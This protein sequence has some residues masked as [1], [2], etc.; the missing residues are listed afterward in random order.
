[1]KPI[2]GYENLSESE[3]KLFI[4][5][6]NKHLSVVDPKE[7]GQYSLGNVIKVLP[8]PQENAVNVEFV[9][10]QKRIYSA[11]GARR[12]ALHSSNV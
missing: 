2:Q 9:N 6:H 7:R 1:M 12:H 11:K 4:I 10:G 5:A 8:N 3:R